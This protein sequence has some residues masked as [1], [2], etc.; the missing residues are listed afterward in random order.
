MARS[1]HS[2]EE[3][4]CNLMTDY[5]A[6]RWFRAPE[7]L[8][9]S[10]RL[11]CGPLDASWVK[12]TRVSVFLKGFPLFPGTSTLNQLELILK[13]F[14]P[15]TKQ[16]M[17]SISSNF[18]ASILSKYVPRN[19]DMLQLKSYIGQHISDI[20]ISMLIK[21]LVFNPEKR[22]SA[23]DCLKHS[24]FV[25]YRNPKNEIFLS[26][27]L[28]PPIND[29]VKLDIDHYRQILFNP[30]SVKT[31]SCDRKQHNVPNKPHK[32][33]PKPS[34]TPQDDH[35]SGLAKLINGIK[36]LFVGKSTDTR[37]NHDK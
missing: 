28:I 20:C 16:D 6:T 15:A 3:Q 25:P 22:I 33:R 11:I 36:N 34:N 18:S 12:Y 7:I 21:L 8:L 27:D 37:Q 26:Y 32:E 10:R 24:Y 19:V 13:Y 29:S 31:L 1:I 35:Q 14:P 2:A 4:E 5:I 9:S 30:N 17:F 23:F